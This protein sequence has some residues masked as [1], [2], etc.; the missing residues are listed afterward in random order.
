M[1][2]DR[3]RFTMDNNDKPLTRKDKDRVF[4][5]L[6]ICITRRFWADIRHLPLP[7][8]KCI[9]LA[10]FRLL[11]YPELA[12]SHIKKRSTHPELIY[13]LSNVQLI[14]HEIHDQQERREVPEDLRPAD[15][16]DYL[17]RYKGVTL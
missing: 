13:D 8:D 3:M 10:T 6:L 14:G 12:V 1:K 16:I 9:C 15:Y 11:T 7:P 4:R 5:E 2:G 17:K